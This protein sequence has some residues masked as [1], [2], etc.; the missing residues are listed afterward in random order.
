MENTYET[1][2]LRFGTRR[3]NIGGIGKNFS[4]DLGP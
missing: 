2:S 1:R 3:Q 4:H